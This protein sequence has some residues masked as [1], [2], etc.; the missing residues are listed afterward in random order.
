MD[1]LIGDSTSAAGSC[2]SGQCSRP[3]STR[4]CTDRWLGAV[5]GST[6]FR[7]RSRIGKSASWIY[8][9]NLFWPCVE[10][11]TWIYF[12]R[13]LSPPYHPHMIG[14]SNIWLS[15]RGL[16]R[17][18]FTIHIWHSHKTHDQKVIEKL[19]PFEKF[20]QGRKEEAR[21]GGINVDSGRQRFSLKQYSLDQSC[22]V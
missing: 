3:W 11:T 17:G 2:G 12:D 6:Y 9:I 8:N 20:R 15:L 16:A 10:S 1:S 4:F 18:Q 19:S 22:S 14:L 13:H 21:T 7:Q 5:I